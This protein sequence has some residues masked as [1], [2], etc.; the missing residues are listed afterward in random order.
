MTMNDIE[1]R[2]ERVFEWF[3]DD[4]PTARVFAVNMAVVSLSN[5]IDDGGNVNR[6][7]IEAW[8]MSPDI[9]HGYMALIFLASI[10]ILAQKEPRWWTYLFG[11]SYIVLILSSII[12]LAIIHPTA[13][14][15]AAVLRI[16]AL[17]SLL[18]FLLVKNLRGRL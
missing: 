12:V 14:T 5:I 17:N 7:L 10:G 1:R 9:V 3:F 18:I 2:L 6:A 15:F 16:V 11:L 4:Q 13:A 8:D